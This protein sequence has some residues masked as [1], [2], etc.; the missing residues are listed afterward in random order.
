[1]TTQERY[2]G[3][4]GWFQR[5]MPVAESELHFENP[6]QLLVAVILSAQCTDKRVNM[7]T[8]AFF[9]RF[10]TPQQLADA[11]PEEIYPYI[12]AS[13]TRTTKQRIYQRWRGCFAVS[14]VGLYRRISTSCNDCRVSGAKRPMWWESW[15][16]VKRRCRLTLMFFE[17]RPHWAHD[18]SQKSTAGRTAIDQR[19]SFRTASCSPPL[20]DSAR[21]VCLH[22]PQ[23]PL[24]SVRTHRLVPLLRFRT[25]T[26]TGPTQ[27][28][29]YKQNN[30][31][32]ASSRHRSPKH[33]QKRCDQPI[34]TSPQ[35]EI[36]LLLYGLFQTTYADKPTASI[37]GLCR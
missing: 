7:T 27:E 32:E 36:V 10:P 30:R 16:S 8:P 22:G 24:W 17:F 37:C 34:Q 14:L 35:E 25:A 2:Q 6:Y 21:S 5:H 3:I 9:D 11:D 28:T 18:W 31:Q 23:A 12:K 33:N 26:R 4:I 13:P 1:M 29:N 20:V 19:F 15:L